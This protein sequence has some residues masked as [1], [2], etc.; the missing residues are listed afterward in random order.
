MMVLCQKFLEVLVTFDHHKADLRDD[1]HP[2]RNILPSILSKYC[3]GLCPSVVIG[4]G[5]I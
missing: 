3:A 1:V 2:Y 4:T 5:A